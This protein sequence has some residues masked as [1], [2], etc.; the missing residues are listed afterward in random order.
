M[1]IFGDF[2]TRTGLTLE[3]HELLTWV[4]IATLGG[5]ESQLTSHTTGNKNLGKTKDYM[6]EVL[7]DMMPYIG[8]PRTLNALNIINSV[9]DQKSKSEFSHEM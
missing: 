5:Q 9:Y 6:L 7:T 8:Y 3:Q 2:Y 1:V 4:S